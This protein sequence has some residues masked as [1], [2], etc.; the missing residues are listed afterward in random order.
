MANTYPL[1]SYHFLVK[2]GDDETN[3][4]AFSEVSGLQI[5]TTSIEY[6]EGSNKEYLLY[7][8]PG[9]KKYSKITLK[10]GTTAANNLFFEWINKN[11]LNTA[12]RKDV[13][14]SLLNEK[15]EAVVTWSVKN[16]FPVKVDFGSLNASEDKVLIESIELD[17]EGL[18]VERSSK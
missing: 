7:K 9:H 8:M 17:H 5:E 1:P 6:R 13:T 3:N 4:I 16:A 12:D 11:S 15:H 18:T 2:I 10:R 14:I